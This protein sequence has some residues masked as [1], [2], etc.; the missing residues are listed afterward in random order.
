M[1]LARNVGPALGW[2]QKRRGEKWAAWRVYLEGR[3]TELGDGSNV[4][5]G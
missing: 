2:K 1:V 3:V 4:E 5:K